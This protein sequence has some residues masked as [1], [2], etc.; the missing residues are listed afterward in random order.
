MD[1]NLFRN[2]DK[3]NLMSDGLV[4][5][6][7]VMYKSADH[8]FRIKTFR[9]IMLLFI[10]GKISG[11]K[12]DA[13]NFLRA[14]N[15]IYYFLQHICD[16]GS[17]DINRCASCGQTCP[18]IIPFTRIDTSETSYTRTNQY[19]SVTKYITD[20]HIKLGITSEE[21]SS[22]LMTQVESLHL[23]SEVRNCK[24]NFSDNPNVK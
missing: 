17:N 7:N 9:K 1:N 18:L 3:L 10:D 2:L 20:N 5:A 24:Y 16:C 23:I 15:E 22:F 14:A 12:P 13:D 6:F 4:T 11:H 19:L 8:D 21:L